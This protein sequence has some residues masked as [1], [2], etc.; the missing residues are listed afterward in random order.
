VYN[1]AQFREDFAKA[2]GYLGVAKMHSGKL[3]GDALGFIDKCYQVY[4]NAATNRLD[5]LVVGRIVKKMDGSSKPIN[6]EQIGRGID[7]IERENFGRT[8]AGSAGSVLDAND[9]TIT[10]NDA[11]LMGGIHAMLDFYIASPR[12]AQNVI[13]PQFGATV[14]GRELLGLTTFGYT[15]HP[16]TRL[17]EVYVCTNKGRARGAT[18]V[19]YEKTFQEAKSG[20]GF[21]HLIDGN[22]R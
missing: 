5:A 1:K 4:E 21:K 19:E 22:A 13:D 18:F 12:T 16:N 6:L 15:V 7:D 9:W 3:S 17:G 11:W 2:Y 8:N 14:T 10:M 20:G